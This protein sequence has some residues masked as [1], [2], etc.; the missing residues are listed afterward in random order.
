ML[1]LVACSSSPSDGGEDLPAGTDPVPLEEGR[2]RGI[3][4]VP[5]EDDALK[6]AATFAVD[7]V[8]WEVQDGVITLDYDLPVGLVGG[9]VHV[10]MD[11]TL[12]HA[13]HASLTSDQ[14]MASCTAYACV[15]TCVETFVD[16][17]ALPISADIITQR[18]VVEYDG[19]A[20][21]RVV[22]A[23]GFASDPIGIVVFDLDMIAT[24]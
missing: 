3:Y 12:D 17:G 21:D 20:A 16:L 14:G 24:D 23:D 9:E 18:A 11:G 1:A 15:I 22:V 13:K 10:R 6:V 2:Y 19:P 5:V 4:L 7:L 8:K